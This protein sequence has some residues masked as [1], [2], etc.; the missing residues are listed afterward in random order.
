MAAAGKGNANVG[1][2]LTGLALKYDRTEIIRSVL[3]PSTRIA[4]GYQPVLIATRD[5]RVINGLV[6]TETDAYIEVV[7]GETKLSRLAKTDIE[8]R[9]IGDVSVMPAGQVDS[10]KPV[11]FADLVSYLMSLKLATPVTP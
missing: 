1:P 9:K 4:T 10:L 7:D 2:D 3:E 11:E 6:R 8:E 5:G